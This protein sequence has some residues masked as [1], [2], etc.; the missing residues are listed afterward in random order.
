MPNRKLNLRSGT[1]RRGAAVAMGL[2]CALV[3]AACG[4][5]SSGGGSGSASGTTL[6]V[7]LGGTLTTSTPGSLYRSWVNNVISRVQAAHPG[8]TIDVTL[9]P[10]DNDQI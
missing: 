3:I 9:L 10:A 6:Q 5:S 8:T 4:G 7:W 2:A 1:V